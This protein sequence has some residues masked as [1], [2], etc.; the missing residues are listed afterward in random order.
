[1]ESYLL[2]TRV[3]YYISSCG[4]R[5][6]SLTQLF[7]PEARPGVIPSS[8]VCWQEQLVFGQTQSPSKDDT[9]AQEVERDTIIE[10]NG[11]W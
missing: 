2:L 9:P 3:F 5:I 8:P 10:E 11:E 7:Y 1:M 4:L 6:P